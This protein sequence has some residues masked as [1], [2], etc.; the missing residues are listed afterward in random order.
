MIIDE[1][2]H[3][4]GQGR[5]DE[6]IEGARQFSAN[7]KKVERVAWTWVEQAAA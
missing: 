3:I 7:G 4:V 6:R 2:D 1:P 5:G